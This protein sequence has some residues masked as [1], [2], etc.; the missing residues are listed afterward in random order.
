MIHADP[1]SSRA[2][3]AREVLS[4]RN[5]RMSL[6]HNIAVLVLSAVV[7]MATLMQVYLAARGSRQSGESAT[8]GVNFEKGECSGSVDLGG[9]SGQSGGSKEEAPK[10]ADPKLPAQEQPPQKAPEGPRKVGE[11]WSPPPR[12]Q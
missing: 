12:T 6:W 5:Y 3:G 1:E 8:S 2:A 10:G 4:Y 9:K 11:A 7:A